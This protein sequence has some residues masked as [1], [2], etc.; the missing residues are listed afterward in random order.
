ME[1]AARGGATSGWKGSKGQGLRSLGLHIQEA[2]KGECWYLAHSE[3][4]HCPHSE[5]MFP[6]QFNLPGNI[7]TRTARGVDVSRKGK[8]RWEH[9]L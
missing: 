8:L 1:G 2:G 6:P 7:L 9:P 4:W 3:G 5:W